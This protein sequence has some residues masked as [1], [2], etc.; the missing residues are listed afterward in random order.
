VKFDASAFVNALPVL[1][2]GLLMT[3]LLVVAA[4]AVAVAIGVVACAGRLIGG[5]LLGWL[6]TAY[7]SLFRGLPETVLIFWIYFCGPFVFEA[8]LSAFA[9]GVL[10]LS[11]VAGAYL[12]E[13]FRAGVLAV[14]RGQYEAANALGLSFKST[15]VD[16]IAPQALR[17]MLPPFLGFLTILIKNS[18]IVSAIGV[19]ELFY[20]GNTLANDNYKHFEIFTAIGAIYFLMIFPLSLSSRYLERRLARA[21]R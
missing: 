2:S 12:A 1:A 14:P 20:R 3:M 6:S 5:G 7:V 13:I 10:A 9:S 19:A 16:V 15:V 8:R 11:L 21:G 4:L 17:I 18:S